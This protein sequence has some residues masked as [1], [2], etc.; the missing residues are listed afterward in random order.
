MFVLATAGF[1]IGLKNIWQFPHHLALYGGSAFLVVYLAFLLILGLPLLMTQI[2]LGR[3]GRGA[4]PAQGVATLVRRVR[5]P[6]AWRWLGAAAVLAGFLVWSYYNVVAGWVLAYAARAVGGT[7]SGITAE[8]ADSLF[9]ALVRDPEKQLF[10]HSLFVAVTMLV[11]TPSLRYGLE[12]A[13]HY[14]VP[15]IYLSLFLLVG[16]AAGSGSFQPA[17]EYFLRVDFSQ[18]GSDGVLVA[19]GDVFFSL[20]LGVATVMMYGAYLPPGK[21]VARLALYVVL[22]DLAAGVLAGF[23]VF[24]V[25]FAGG[26]LSAAGPGLVFQALS[27]AFDALPLGEVMR[28]L[29]F[30]MLALIAWMSTIGLAEPVLVWLM[31]RYE[32]SRARAALWLGLFGWAVGVV[33]IL[34]LHPWAFSFTVFDVTRTLGFFDVLV[35]VTSVVLLPLVGMA[36]ALFAGWVLR[37]EMTREALAIDSPCL[38]DVWLWLNRVVIPAMLVLLL[39]GIHLFL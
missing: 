17:L 22:A 16:Y 23:A 26:S 8:G 18:L 20:G 14:G 31:Q 4:S 21:P 37:P 30:V 2:M 6:Q 24:P 3:L 5:A 13:V 7:L 32:W 39:S 34:S 9:T 15:L 36:S 28:L 11:L 27:V 12:R 25:L 19:M 38:H 1:V 33:A 35:L 10:W 29:L